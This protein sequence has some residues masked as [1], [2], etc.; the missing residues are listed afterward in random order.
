LGANRSLSESRERSITTAMGS[1]KRTLPHVVK[2]Y[3]VVIR[4]QHLL[5]IRREPRI[6]IVPKY[7]LRLVSAGHEMIVGSI[8]E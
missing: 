2:F 4:S 8:C 3:V 6:R 1:G 7:S 5:E